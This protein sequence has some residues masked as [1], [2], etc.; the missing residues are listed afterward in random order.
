[1]STTSRRKTPDLAALGQ[2]VYGCRTDLRWR[3][4]SIAGVTNLAQQIA[5]DLEDDEANRLEW[6]T[7]GNLY[8]L[9]NVIEHASRALHRDITGLIGE[10]DSDLPTMEGEPR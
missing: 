1:M 3:A 10:C 5:L 4:H 2:A 6:A 7:S 8:A 9:L